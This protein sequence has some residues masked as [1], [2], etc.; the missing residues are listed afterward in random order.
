MNK[1]DGFVGFLVVLDVALAGLFTVLVVFFRVI[2]VLDPLSE[3]VCTDWNV[4][5][6]VVCVVVSIVATVGFFV[7]SFVVFLIVLA[8]VCVICVL[9]GIGEVS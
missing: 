7:T 6:R 8:E 3:V 9:G 1:V 4:D 2:S 5:R